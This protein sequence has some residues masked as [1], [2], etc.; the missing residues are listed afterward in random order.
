MKKYP[1][2]FFG[3]YKTPIKRYTSYF[4]G[5]YLY[6]VT[7]CNDDILSESNILTHSIGLVEALL[8]FSE[9]KIKPNHIIAM[10]PPTLSFTSIAERIH[11][12]DKVLSGIYQK[13]NNS[14]INLSEWT[15]TIFRN[16]NK[17]IDADVDLYSKIIYYTQDT[18][19]PYQIK[20]VRDSII[21]MLKSA[22]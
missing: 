20:T 12:E 6:S 5:F 15:I 7:D 1:V 9:R 17:N 13:Y 19:H 3:G 10:D 21:S 11:G 16:K 18:H 4:P 22:K 2:I 8:Y 14:N